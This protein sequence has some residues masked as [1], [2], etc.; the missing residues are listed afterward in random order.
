MLST[1]FP[2]DPSALDPWARRQAVTGLL[3]DRIQA[4]LME[5][6]GIDR[7]SALHLAIELVRRGGTIS[8]I[9]VYGG[10]MD[11]MPMLTLF[12]KQIQLRLGQANVKRWIDDIMPL[13]LDDSD[14]ARGTRSGARK[15][16]AGERHRTPRRA[17]LACQMLGRIGRKAKRRKPSTSAMAAKPMSRMPVCVAPVVPASVGGRANSCPRISPAAFV[18][19]W[20]LM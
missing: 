11:P 10:M 14:P 7:L 16:A 15:S 19:V 1:E 6:F 18:S 8:I 9:G 13:L 4:P 3:P 20:R 2:N 5:K 12:D 17:G